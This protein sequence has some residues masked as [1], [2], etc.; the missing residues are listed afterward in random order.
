MLAVE[1]AGAGLGAEM[2]TVGFPEGSSQVA[3]ALGA[4]ISVGS[5]AVAY[6][7]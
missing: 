7:V 3:E 6:C 2:R 1:S 5:W 4:M